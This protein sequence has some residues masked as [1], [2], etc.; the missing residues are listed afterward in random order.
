M[1]FS[2]GRTGFL[3]F[4]SLLFDLFFY[5]YTTCIVIVAA[6]LLILP[7]EWSRLFFHLWAHSFLWLCR[8]GLGLTYSVVQPLPRNRTVIAA[9]HQ[10]MWETIALAALIPNS[11]FILKKTLLWIPFV[12]WHLRK[13][14]M[15]GI[16]RGCKSALPHMLLAAK[17]ALEN[18]KTLIIFP[19]GRRTL[20]GEQPPLKSGVWHLAQLSQ[21]PI[22]AVSL[23][24]GLYWPR[25][26]LI[27]KPGHINITSSV[28]PY[29]Q[30]KRQFLDHLKSLLN[31]DA[32]KKSASFF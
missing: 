24:S 7:S 31:A 28:L 29:N 5:S 18:H 22:T 1:L 13:L 2:F 10:S 17:Q 20:P 6:P 12:G 32:H 26:S 9:K 30:N 16:S 14:G 3:L 15:I 23:N 11:I 25:K 21:S 27:K 19:E 4:R 8:H